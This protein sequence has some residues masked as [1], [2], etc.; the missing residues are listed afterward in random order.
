MHFFVSETRTKLNAP[1]NVYFQWAEKGSYRLEQLLQTINHLPNRSHPFSKKDF[2]IYVLDDYAVHLMPEVR[3]AFFKRGYVLVVIG[4][5]ITGDIQINDTNIHAPL[6]ARYRELETEL[7]LEKLRNESDKIPSP[8]RDDMMSMIKTA[9]EK[10]DESVD[11]QNA[12]KRLFI[13][14]ALDGS[15]DHMVSDKLFQLIGPQVTEFRNNLM[16]QKAP[17]KFSELIK[18]ITPP[19]GVRRKNNIEGKLILPFKVC[20]SNLK[21]FR[22]YIIFLHRIQDV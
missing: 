9:M 17:T 19:K 15:E 6:K 7:M 11:V 2:A 22:L 20:F 4:G 16:T 8:S 5:G 10:I 14:N 13:T 18:S 1:E 12:F 21:C 3:E